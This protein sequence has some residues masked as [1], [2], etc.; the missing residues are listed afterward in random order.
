M[1][2]ECIPFYSPGLDLTVQVTAAVKGKTFLNI[3]GAFDPV[4]G[5]VA[6][7]NTAAA[8]GLVI[9]VASRDAASDAR[10][11]VIRGPGRIVPV[12]AGGAIAAGD[13]V[14]VG[15]GGK[16][17]KLASGKAVARAWSAGVNNGD[18]AVSLY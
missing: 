12:T 8:A 7:A 9:G 16:A 13:E 10:V 15:A 4:A 5:T 11:A 3:T 14:E 2:N 6:K 1:A 17:V 18:V